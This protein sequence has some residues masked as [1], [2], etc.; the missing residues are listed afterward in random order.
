MAPVGLLFGPAIDDTVHMAPPLRSET[1]LPQ[2][3]GWT[4]VDAGGGRA[5]GRADEDPA[6]WERIAAI[7]E[8]VRLGATVL[9]DVWPGEPG[10]GVRSLSGLTTVRR[11]GIRQGPDDTVSIAY[12]DLEGRCIRRGEVSAHYPGLQLTQA[13]RPDGPAGMTRTVWSSFGDWGEMMFAFTGG[14]PDCLEG[15]SFDPRPLPAGG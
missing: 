15:I 14:T 13:P 8:R 2:A 12:M 3:D 10:N 11:S 5:Q 7:A 6:L 9:R 1:R 4:S